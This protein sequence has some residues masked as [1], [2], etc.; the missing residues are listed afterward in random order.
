M[1][2][3]I[4]IGV[5]VSA[6]QWFKVGDHDQVYRPP[7]PDGEEDIICHH[8]GKVF[9]AHGRLS[10]YNF[11]HDFF[12]CPGDWIINEEGVTKRP[13]SNYDF[14]HCYKKIKK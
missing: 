13:M 1:G 2:K 6:K 12:V 14:I 8:C 11:D 7:L 4:K 10:A 5:I 3:Y 9:T